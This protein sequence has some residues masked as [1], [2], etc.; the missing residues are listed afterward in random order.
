V[1][2]CAL[3]KVGFWGHEMIGRWYRRHADAAAVPEDGP[4]GFDD[5]DVSLGDLMRGERATL[6]K[7][8]L[9]V[10]RELRIKASYIAA[11]ENRDVAAFDTPSFIAGYVRSYARYL[12]MEPDAA[13][14]RFCA[15]ANFSVA[16]GLSAA[17][18]SP[19]LVA[20]KQRKAAEFADPLANPIFVPRREHLLDQIDPRAMGSM[21]V[22]LALIGV[23]G[24]GGW[25]VLRQIQQV[26]LAPVD[27][28]P[29]VVAS[30]DP[31]ANVGVP[32]L[33]SA[34]VDAA[35]KG[36]MA[37][38]MPSDAPDDGFTVSG[39]APALAVAST[40]ARPQALDVPVLSPRD[41]PIGALAPLRRA[42]L[43]QSV[44]S[45]L[46]EMVFDEETPAKPQVQVLADAAPK[47]ELF[48]VRPAWVRVQAAD[49][50]IL[51]E[52]ILDAGERYS[53]PQSDIPARLRAGNAGSVYFAVA[54]KTYGPARADGGVAKNVT[55][56]VDAL[57]KSYSLADLTRDADLARMVAVAQAQTGQ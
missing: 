16:H 52:K 55:L 51:F 6:G 25:S 38:L 10:Q 33:D 31:L 5:Y 26:D 35:V 32:A 23:I 54:G 30:L 17:A 45:V 12:G 37:A 11:I 49:G 24:Y 7:S 50:T 19:Q 4:R 40:G 18:S 44:D 29:E 27:Q 9:D 21:L 39:G 57:T 42:D 34:A 36:A 41:G 56:S 46:A 13:Y 43:R 1:R 8:L 20:A 22:L 15:E 47:L 3:K 14:A 53:V 28:A 2:C 48:A